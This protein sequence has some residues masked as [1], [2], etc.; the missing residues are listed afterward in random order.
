M[1]DDRDGLN[2]GV[3]F[4]VAAAYD[5]FS[6]QWELLP[7]KLF[8]INIWSKTLK[9]F[10]VQEINA[11]ADHCVKEFLRPPVPFEFV[12]LAT[13]FRE[14]KSMSD[15]IVSKL[16]RMAYLILSNEEFADCGITHS[17]ISDACLIAAAISNLNAYAEISVDMDKKYIHDE[18]SGRA[19]MFSNEAA[20]WKK[21][22]QDGKG[23]WV[24]SFVPD[25][26]VVR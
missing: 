4:A 1:F 13:R 20:N 25:V 5:K 9:K 15:P 17:D 21:L 8:W 6:K 19:R 22:A 7:D 23:Y 26:P 3:Q 14:G 24:G 10:T 2:S 18:H 16:E 12:E 11:A